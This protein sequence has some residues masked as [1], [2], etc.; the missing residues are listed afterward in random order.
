MTWSWES[1]QRI[2]ALLQPSWFATLIILGASLTFQA[3]QTL[4]VIESVAADQGALSPQHVSLM[5]FLLILA[6]SGWYFPRALLSVQYWN[7]PTPTND[8]EAQLFEQWRRY[9]PRFLGTAP[10]LS[11][12]VGFFRVGNPGYGFTYLVFAASFLAAVVLRRRHLL[13]EKTIVVSEPTIS[14]ETFRSLVALLCLSFVIFWAFVVFPI[15]APLIVGS[16]GIVLYAAAS[17]IAFGCLVLI[18]PTYRY[19]LPSL[20][21]VMI[22]LSG[23]FGLWNDN[24]TIR[25]AADEPESWMR[26]S[27]DQHLDAW[28]DARQSQWT[29]ASNGYPVY[30]ASAEGGGIRAGYWTASVLGKLED[31]HP[32]F[33][34]HLLAIS[35]VSGGSL[36]GGVFSALIADRI[37]QNGY[38]CAE[39]S[40]ATRAPLLPLIRQMLGHDFLS[41]TLAGLF[42]PD[43]VQRLS[44]LAGSWTF[45]DR[46]SYLERSWEQAWTETTGTDRFQASFR[47][48]WESPQARYTVPS[49]FLN[50]TWVDSGDRSIASNIALDP[51]RFAR[52]DDLM[53]FAMHS[54]PASAA[55][56]AS[57]RFTYVSPPGTIQGKERT[58]QVV[59]G[60]YFENSGTLTAG[61]IARA[62]MAARNRYCTRQSQPAAAHCLPPDIK[63]VIL[64]LSNDPH[65]PNNASAGD[66]PAAPDG[67]R[68]LAETLAPWQTLFH[69]RSARGYVSEHA[70]TREFETI[71]FALGD[72]KH[73]DVPLGWMLSKATRASIDQQIDQLRGLDSLSH[74]TH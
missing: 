67:Q 26:E 36:G 28:L 74:S 50:A 48:L 57:A 69:T 25:P 68:F 46:A 59:D 29:A 54:L 35:G 39:A 5:M 37:Q 44:P 22:V 21:V 53:T 55:I 65:N 43:L 47:Q 41:P 62:L 6:I 12:A 51:V 23:L 31:T 63:P 16:A 18:H 7:T 19:R 56:H 38:E 40:H 1:V 30:I 20:F 24:H 71:R 45:P 58:R 15:Q 32:G 27:I 9:F 14:P 61:E 2:V 33:A 66:R 49:L 13:T 52:A 34:C 72:Y 4:D 42:F 64:I 73:A 11:I 60:G 17:W 8:R 10:I 70:V 3:D